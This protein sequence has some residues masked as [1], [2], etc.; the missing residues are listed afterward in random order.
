MIETFLICLISLQLYTINAHKKDSLHFVKLA[1]FGLLQVSIILL[2]AN[3]SFASGLQCRDIFSEGNSNDGLQQVR[4]TNTELSSKVL[5]LV[6]ILQSGDQSVV[7]E[8]TSTVTSLLQNKG[9]ELIFNP[10]KTFLLAPIDKGHFL[11]HLADKLNTRYSGLNIKFDIKSMGAAS[12]YHKL[13]NTIFLPLEMAYA[14][15]VGLTIL[16]HEIS[17]ANRHRKR[18]SGKSG[19]DGFFVN[20]KIG[21][22]DLEEMLT[23]PMELRTLKTLLKNNLN[24]KN[25]LN[26]IERFIVLNRMEFL[27]KRL[28]LISKTLTENIVET[29]QTINQVNDKDWQLWQYTENID[30]F[31]AKVF[32][33]KPK[34]K[35]LFLTV[36]KGPTPYSDL[37]TQKSENWVHL[38]LHTETGSFLRISLVNNEKYENILSSQDYNVKNIK[39]LFIKNLTLLEQMTS[40]VQQLSKQ[41]VANFER[42]PEGSFGQ[43]DKIL[44]V[45][46]SFENSSRLNKD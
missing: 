39:L 5:D 3:S 8:I 20:S 45:V 26:K 2:D 38:G 29:V 42:S 12:S 10:D 31:D 35:N 24:G 23:Y 16:A 7:D 36:H 1:L 17:H 13:K 25:N 30:K 22:E 18:L 28:N 19:F 32:A 40:Q 37:E 15:D 43:I 27:L 41:G 14:P 4:T 11:N 34:S 6:K 21:K 44:A 9:V 33:A 46:R